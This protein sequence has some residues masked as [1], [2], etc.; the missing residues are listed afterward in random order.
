[1]GIFTLRNKNNLN[2][3]KYYGF[4]KLII[5]LMPHTHT[6]ENKCL[7]FYSGGNRLTIVAILVNEEILVG[8]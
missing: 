7:R 4:A 8:F 6:G 2:K 1:M 3:L 5:K